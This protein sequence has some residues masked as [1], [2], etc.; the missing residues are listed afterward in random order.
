MITQKAVFFPNEQKH[1]I[2]IS[3]SCKDFISK[4]LDK[5]PEGRLGSKGD[6]EEVLKHEWLADIEIDNIEK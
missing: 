4:L 6:L 2:S 5:D 3:S 1:G